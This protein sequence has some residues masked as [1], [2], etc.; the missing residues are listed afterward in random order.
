MAVKV[1]SLVESDIAWAWTA[2]KWVESR[3][4]R[5]RRTP[6]AK[7]LGREEW[8]EKALGMRL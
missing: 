6:G 3:G 1:A 4:W 2:V 8:S 5:S 7:V